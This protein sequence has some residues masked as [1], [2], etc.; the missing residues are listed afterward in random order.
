MKRNNTKYTNAVGGDI[1]KHYGLVFWQECF[2]CNKEFRREAGYRFQMQIN[3]DWV[4]SCA[5]CSES[6][7]EVN[8]NV[9][10]FMSNR[11]K[12]PAAPL[13]RET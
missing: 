11:P 10:K 1:Y 3:R 7:E 13:Q 2:F 12:G 6:K 9:K 8:E 5:D 4:Y